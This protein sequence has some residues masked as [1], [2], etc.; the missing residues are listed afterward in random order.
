MQVIN[1]R[2]I[3]IYATCFT[4][5]VTSDLAIRGMTGSGI[6]TWTC[7]CDQAQV[8]KFMVHESMFSLVYRLA[9]WHRWLNVSAYDELK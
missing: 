9:R 6:V 1:N 8:V 5:R 3:G 4:L 2:T 7:R